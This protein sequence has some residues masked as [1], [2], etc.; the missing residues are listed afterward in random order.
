MTRGW[1]GQKSTG[2]SVS[3]EGLPRVRLEEI[4]RERWDCF[5]PVF[6]AWTYRYLCLSRLPGSVL[7]HPWLAVR[8]A[9]LLA[10]V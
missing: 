4:G 6:P 7:G 5:K 9:R 8:E 10:A 1:W 3:A 2:V